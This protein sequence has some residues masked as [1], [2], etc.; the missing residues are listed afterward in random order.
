MD[1]RTAFERIFAHIPQAT[2]RVRV[3]GG[4][5][6]LVIGPTLASIATWDIAVAFFAELAKSVSNAQL[7]ILINDIGLSAEN[8]SRYREDFR[9]PTVY[10]D[11]LKR[12]QV[13]K[14]FVAVRFEKSIKNRAAV[15]TKKL[16]FRQISS[17]DDDGRWKYSSYEL[18]ADV[19]LTSSSGVPQCS[20]LMGQMFFDIGLKYDVTVDFYSTQVRPTMERASV[21]AQELYKTNCKIINCYVNAEG[22]T[23]QGVYAH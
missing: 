5:F 7:E 20:L 11:I 3:E 16:Q 23:S 6:Q 10:Q 15:F 2:R 12:S 18:G 14:E 19:P 21:V 22:S 9:L 1:L 13:P 17:K 4:H 8:R